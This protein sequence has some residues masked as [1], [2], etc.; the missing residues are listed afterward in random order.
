MDHRSMTW[1]WNADERVSVD[2]AQSFQG[3]IDCI[4]SLRASERAKERWMT[5]R[6]DSIVRYSRNDGND[7]MTVKISLLTCA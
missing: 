6:F 4:I 3:V 5:F 1:A 2:M 7:M